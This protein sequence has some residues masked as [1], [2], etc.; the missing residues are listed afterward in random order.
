M[1][2]QADLSL[3]WAHMPLCWFCHKAAQITFP[4]INVLNREWYLPD[5]ADFVTFFKGF[6]S[7]MV[8]IYIYEG[9]GVSH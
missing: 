7:L 1:D 8:L 4:G 2:A 9:L 5:F 3:R 6:I